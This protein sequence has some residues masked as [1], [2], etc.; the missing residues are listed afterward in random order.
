[1]TPS[2]SFGLTLNPTK[3]E[4]TSAPPFQAHVLR[5]QIFFYLGPSNFKQD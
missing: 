5:V 2:S 1:M 4:T 3:K